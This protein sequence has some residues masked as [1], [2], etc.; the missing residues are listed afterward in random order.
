M[1]LGVLLGF[2]VA[3]GFYGLSA[4]VGAGLIFAGVSD[5]CMMGMLLARMPW[6]SAS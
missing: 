2:F 3:P 5:T 4:F 1:L 6:N